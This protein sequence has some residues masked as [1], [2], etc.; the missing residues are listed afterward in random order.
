MQ[1]IY[2]I[3]CLVNGKVYIGQSIDLDSRLNGHRTGEHNDCLRED[4]KKYGLENFIFDILEE[5][6]RERLTEREQFFMDF[7]ESL[8]P[9]KGYNKR[10][11]DPA[12]PLSEE[13][14]RKISEAMKGKKKSPEHIEKV[15]QS[16]LGRKHKPDRDYSKLKYPKSEEHKRRLSESEKG[17]LVSPETRKKMSEAHRGKP[18]SEETRRKISKTRRKAKEK[19]L[20]TPEIHS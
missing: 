3:E 1:G 5:V 17:K 8:N 2:K 9:E 13:H 10:A 20:G 12:R 7:Y 4:M 19:D 15:R 6:A 14:R 11:A 16:C 18:L